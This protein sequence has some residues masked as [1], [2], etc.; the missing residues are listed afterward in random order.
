MKAAMTKAA[1]K[2]LAC[3]EKS[4]ICQL[5]K[6]FRCLDPLQAGELDEREADVIPAGLWDAL[7]DVN[8]GD[9]VDADRSAVVCGTITDDIIAQVT[10]G[11]ALVVDVGEDDEDEA[12]TRPTA[13]E[14]LQPI[15]DRRVFSEAPEARRRYKQYK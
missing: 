1:H 11:E 2:A 7:G 6:D 4:D 12:P 13:S 5:F 15:R 10:G 9:Y 14:R 3:L 8:F